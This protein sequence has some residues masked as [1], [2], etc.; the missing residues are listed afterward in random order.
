MTFWHRC[1]WNRRFVRNER[2]PPKCLYI[3]HLRGL[4]AFKNLTFSVKDP[5][6]KSCFSGT[7]SGTLFC[8]LFEASWCQNARFWDPLALSGAQNCGQNHPSGAKGLQKSTRTEVLAGTGGHSFDGLAS[9]IDFGAF[10]GTILI[11]LGWFSMDLVIISDRVWYSFASTFGDI[12]VVAHKFREDDKS[13]IRKNS[14]AQQSVFG[15]PPGQR[16][17]WSH[18]FNMRA[19]SIFW[20]ST[21]RRFNRFYR[22]CMKSKNL[23]FYNKSN[24][25]M[26]P[27]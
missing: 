18:I 24:K 16:W 8:W 5:I 14:K 1:S 15:I 21:R 19:S 4:S 13:I 27:S 17:N 23:G 6:K 3:K 11:D 20:I 7:L 10:L 9:K 25:T 26:L 22:I 12:Q 2:K